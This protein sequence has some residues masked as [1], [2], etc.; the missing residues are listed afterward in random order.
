VF[1]LTGK[2]RGRV[3]SGLVFSFFHSVF[4]ALD[5]FAVLWIVSHLGNLTNQV[6]ATA[7][8]I[9]GIGLL[10]KCI[11]KWQTTIRVSES[12]YDIFRDKRIHIGDQLKSA[13][14]GYFSEQNLG[15]IQSAVTSGMN[16]L[17]HSAMHAVENILGGL[18]YS[19]VCIL[20]LLVYNWKVG[21]ISLLGLVLGIAVLTVSQKRALSIAPVQIKASETMIGSVL[22]FIQG[23]AVLRLF[24]RERSGPVSVTETFK[25]KRETDLES[26]KLVMWPVHFFKYIFKIIGCVI[27]LV[28]SLDALHGTID[29]SYCV[30]FLF[31][32]F[33]IYARI[34][35]LSSP[36]TQLRTIDA[37]LARFEKIL[38]MP[39]VESGQ[40]QVPKKRQIEFKNVGF[41]Y[42]DRKVIRNMSFKI[43]EKSVTAIVGPSGGGKSTICNLIARFWD[44]QEGQILYGGINV[45]RF[46]SD[47]LLQNISMVFQDVYLFRDTIE[48]NI[49][50]GQPEASQAEIEEVAKRARCHDFI[51]KLPDGYQTLVGEGGS[52]LSGGEKQRIS[53]A[54]AMLKDA[55]IVILDEATS[56]VDPENEFEL[57]HSIK[58]LTKNK[59]LITIAHRLSTVS[60]ADQILV[61]AGGE[62]V[63]RGKHD[64]LMGAEGIYQDF[65]NARNYAASWQL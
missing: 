17:E 30:L 43:P 56:S 49:R 1:S 7:V 58:E 35:A 51:M 37:A 13:P 33:N 48:N 8:G 12:G 45:K 53:I 55:P 14:M 65:I 64:E 3:I 28:S 4:A 39:V 57:V 44:V 9:L 32:A 52:S 54:R 47:E 42:D 63:Q 6:I 24:N 38:D 62:I 46:R 25:A 20:V 34:E 60:H 26:E 15:S 23:V 5:L 11:C 40:E 61:V 31:A 29:F 16:E 36:V 41:S 21:L 27:I 2:Y 10:G 59:T 19:A 50:F 22:E 18:L